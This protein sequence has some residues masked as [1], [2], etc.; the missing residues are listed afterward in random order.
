VTNFSGQNFE[1]ESVD[2]LSSNSRLHEKMID[3]L[4]NDSIGL[5]SI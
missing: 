3:V 2:M 5:F 4:K 1:L